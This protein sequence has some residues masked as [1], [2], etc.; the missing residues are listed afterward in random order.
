MKLLRYGPVGESGQAFLMRH[1]QFVMQFEAPKQKAFIGFGAAQKSL[2]REIE[3]VRNTMQARRKPVLFLF[4]I[5][6]EGITL[7]HYFIQF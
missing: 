4:L 5:D 2:D 1:G 3:D 7:R 6:Q